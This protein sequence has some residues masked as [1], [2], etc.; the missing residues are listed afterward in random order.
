MRRGR[1]ALGRREANDDTDVVERKQD[2]SPGQDRNEASSPALG[3]CRSMVS[4]AELSQRVRWSPSHVNKF[5]GMLLDAL[6]DQHTHSWV[7]GHVH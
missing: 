2:R 4:P 5:M 7:Q 3:P 6:H 1:G